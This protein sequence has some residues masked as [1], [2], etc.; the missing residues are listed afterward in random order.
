MI[1]VIGSFSPS[2]LATPLG[3]PD[4]VIELVAAI[5]SISI[6]IIAARASRCPNCRVNL[7]FFAM[8]NKGAG[9]WLKWLVELETCPK[10]GYPENAIANPRNA[11]DKTSKGTGGS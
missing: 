2:I 10:C 5:T 1:S 9:R 8:G 6:L 11:Q 3:I 7:L 4:Y